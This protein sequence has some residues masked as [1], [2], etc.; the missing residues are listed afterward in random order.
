[1]KDLMENSAFKVLHSHLNDLQ[2]YKF[3][4]VKLEH[5][6]ARFVKQTIDGVSTIT[7]VSEPNLRDVLL[8]LRL[9]TDYN[10]EFV[11]EILKECTH[12]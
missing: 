8:F 4:G 3:G 1:M 9:Y 5:S 12:P 11:S 2:N 6:P 10:I 7:K